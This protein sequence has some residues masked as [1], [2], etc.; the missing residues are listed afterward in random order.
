MKLEVVKAGGAAI[1]AVLARHKPIMDTSL[2]RD[3]MFVVI[4]N[5]YCWQVVL[6][7]RLD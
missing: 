7:I 5:P 2:G 6:N 3:V 4:A 1:V